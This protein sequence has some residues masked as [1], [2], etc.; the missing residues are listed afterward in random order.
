RDPSLRQ[1]IVLMIPRALGLGLVNL[2]VLIATRIASG[3]G[4]GS[5]ASYNRGWSLMQLPE[6]LIGT[7]MGIV[8]FPTLATLS[9][10]GDLRGKRS[11][12]SGALRFIL[13]AT[14]PA[15]VAMVLAGRPLLG[16]LEG[17]AFQAGDADR[18][19][20]VVQ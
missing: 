2:N 4:S 5:V 7:A 8:I 14:I 13:I 17:G 16:L 3:L 19:F 10:A 20:R 6:T 12:M 1:V 9:A 11:A 15:I 18:V